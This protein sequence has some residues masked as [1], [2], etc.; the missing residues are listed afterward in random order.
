[1]ATFR[2]QP[3][4][5]SNATQWMQAAVTTNEEKAVNIVLFLVS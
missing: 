5:G 1:M 3:T 4:G 2:S